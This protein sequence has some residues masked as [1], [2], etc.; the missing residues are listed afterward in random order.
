MENNNQN[1]VGIFILIAIILIGIAL[2]HNSDPAISEPG[3]SEKDTTF[4]SYYEELDIRFKKEQEGTR[5][6]RDSLAA[7]CKKLGGEWGTY[8]CIVGAREYGYTS[9]LPDA[10]LKET[11][12]SKRCFI[13]GNFL[14]KDI[15]IKDYKTCMDY[16]DYL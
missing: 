10:K 3:S 2:F 14:A 7:Q 5:K 11:P 9:T 12:D 13:Y 6:W 4:H 15:P 8:R 1:P 16:F